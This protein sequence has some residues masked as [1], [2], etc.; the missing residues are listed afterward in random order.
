MNTPNIKLYLAISGVLIVLFLI[1]IFVPFGKK[2]TKPQ[3]PIHTVPTP[4][5]VIV[6]QSHDIQNIVEEP[7]DFTGVADEEIPPNIANTAA[8]KQNLM[9]QTPF[10]S[11]LFKVDFDYSE[12]KFIIT[13]AEPKQESRQQFD[14]WLKD[15]Y[16]NL[17]TNQ[18]NF[19]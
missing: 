14:Q 3:S 6:D 19:R 11:G 10:D 7:I 13:L 15:N 17:S 18:F 9:N 5:L 4:T 8:E 16:P 1:V 2:P 12:D